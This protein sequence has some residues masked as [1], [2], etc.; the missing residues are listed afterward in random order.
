MRISNLLARQLTQ[1][2]GLL[3]SA[4]LRGDTGDDEGHLVIRG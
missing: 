1:P 3:V 4:A 2:V